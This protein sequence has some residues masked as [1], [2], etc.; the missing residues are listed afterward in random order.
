MVRTADILVAMHGSGGTWT[1]FMRKPYSYLEIFPFR[2]QDH[3]NAGAPHGEPIIA[4]GKST[5]QSG[6]MYR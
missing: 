1:Y 5:L 2:V 3:I 4:F 6:G